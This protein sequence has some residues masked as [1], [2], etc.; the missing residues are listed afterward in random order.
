MSPATSLLTRFATLTLA[1]ALGACTATDA[2]D[3]TEDETVDTL[4][5]LPDFVEDC[6]EG[7][8]DSLDTMSGLLGENNKD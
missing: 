4:P 2:N 6:D 3:G 8:N 1:L 5:P 7:I